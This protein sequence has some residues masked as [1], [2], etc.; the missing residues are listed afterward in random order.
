MKKKVELPIVEPIYGTYHN[1]GCG[2][3]TIYENQSIR[4]WYLNEAVNLRCNRK[5]ISGYTTPEIYIEMSNLHENPYLCIHWFPLQCIK[6]SINPIIRE[7]IDQGFYIYFGDFDD[8]YIPGKTWYKQRHFYHDGLIYGYNQE[9]KTYYI[10]SYDSN[11]ILNKYETPQ[12]AIND[13]RKAAMK[14]AGK[15][16][17][18]AIKPSQ[19]FIAFDSQIA[20]E[21]I[22]EYLDSSLEKYP[23]TDETWVLG[24]VVQ[25]YMVMYIEKLQD[26][27]IPYE[28]MDWR[29]FRLIWEHKKVMQERLEKIEEDLELDSKTSQKYKSIVKEADTMRMLYASH[30]MKRRDSIL[31]II[32]Q[33]L[34]NLKETELNLLTEFVDKAGGAIKKC[35]YGEV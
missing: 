2:A 1:Q 22:K 23:P 18:C 34:L 17:L 10:Y 20:L 9:K 12:E 30:H 25:E 29:I 6:R 31:P 19:E 14:N 8:Y 24:I 11:W 28:K 27:S 33:K 7:M 32:Q 15:G 16:I 3:A 13:S 4:N 21:K 5:F 26:G 35:N